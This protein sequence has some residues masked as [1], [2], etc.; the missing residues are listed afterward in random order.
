MEIWKDIP[1]FEN[2]YQVS[3]LGRVKSLS[4]IVYNRGLTPFIKKEK[5]LT[6]RV[7]DNLYLFITFSVNGKKKNFYIHQLV[8]MAFLGHKPDRFNLVIN[9]KNHNV[10]DNSVWNLEIVTNRENSSKRQFKYSSQYAGVCFCNN[11]KKFKA[12]IKINNKL[13]HLGYFVNET[14]AHNA[15][16]N[17]LK[18]IK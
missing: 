15:Y 17:E 13:K 3:N 12:G 16:Q 2:Y 10:T 7:K 11:S 18:N 8:A 4:R 14:D 6:N 9:H 5:I 1:N